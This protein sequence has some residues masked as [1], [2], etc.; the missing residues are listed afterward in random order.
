MTVLEPIAAFGRRAAP[1]VLLATSAC[2]TGALG[3][4]PRV[5]EAKEPV[6]WQIGMYTYFMSVPRDDDASANRLSDLLKRRSVS[7][8][9]GASITRNFM[10][11]RTRYFDAV[12]AI[13]GDPE[14][15]ERYQI[16]FNDRRARWN[17]GERPGSESKPVSERR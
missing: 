12:E 4:D 2:S 17:A 7:H 5:P 14:L 10:I 11:D 13:R 1:F 9:T 3:F 16:E 8:F 15:Y 6:P